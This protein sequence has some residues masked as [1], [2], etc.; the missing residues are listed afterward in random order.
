MQD[1]VWRETGMCVGSCG[2]SLDKFF[3]DE[4][5]NDALQLV[6][7]DVPARCKHKA[8]RRINMHA[9]K[10]ANT[11]KTPDQAPKPYTQENAR[12]KTREACQRTQV[13][14]REKSARA[15]TK[16]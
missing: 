13:A 12:Q 1:T 2:A 10:H 8:N 9:Q 11:H 14:T 6:H 5:A 16:I 3:L 15:G 7:T 4:S